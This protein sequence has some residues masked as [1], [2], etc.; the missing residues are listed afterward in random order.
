MGERRPS[1]TVDELTAL[2]K[3]KL[4]QYILTD[5]TGGAQTYPAAASNKGELIFVTDAKAGAGDVAYS[6]G[7]IWASV[8]D[9]LV[10]S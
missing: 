1:E 7:T 5:V 2:T 9:G 4:P 10:V 3:F 8:D 6:N